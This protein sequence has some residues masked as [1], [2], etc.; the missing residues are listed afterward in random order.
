MAYDIYVRKSWKDQI[1][2]SMKRKLAECST[3]RASKLS[4]PSVLGQPSLLKKKAKILQAKAVTFSRERKGQAEAL[5]I[6]VT[7]HTMGVDNN[8][9]RAFEEEHTGKRIQK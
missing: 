2:P 6:C 1:S 5:S 8:R 4:C 9:G 3:D 7:F